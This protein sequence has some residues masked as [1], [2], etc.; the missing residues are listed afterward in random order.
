[1]NRSSAFL[2]PVVQFG[3]ADADT[4]PKSVIAGAAARRTSSMRIAFL[5]DGSLSHVR[6]WTRYFHERGHAVLLLSFED[7][8]GCPFPAR[9]LKA[10]LPT[11]LLGYTSAMR[12]IKR[13]LTSFRP[14]VLNALYLGGYG[15]LAARSGVRPFAASSLGSDLLIDYPSSIVHRLQ[16]RYVLRTANLLI[17]DAEELSRIAISLGVN[18]DSILK[19]YMGIDEA[20]FFPRDAACAGSET[21]RP[22]IVSTRNLYPVYHVDLLV[23]AAPIIREKSD[24]VFVVCG[25]GPE[26]GRLEAMVRKLGM[27][28]SFEFKGRCTPAEIAEELRAAAIYVSTSTSDSTSVSLLEAMACGVFPIVTDLPANREWITNGTN[29]LVVPTDDPRVLAGAVLQVLGR[30]ELAVNARGRNIEIIRERGLWKDNMGR[31]EEA[32]E[33]LLAHPPR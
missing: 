2:L 25:E 6:R 32:F 30:R 8:E 33:R 12:S 26:R 3:A 14:D 28:R 10:Y 20:V 23:E 16:I 13:E 27:E 31:V 17:T 4:G 9:R 7:I 29:G 24:A 22:R 15:F 18:P 1:M 5:G 21:G 19:A 11:K